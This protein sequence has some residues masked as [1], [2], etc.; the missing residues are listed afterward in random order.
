MKLNDVRDSAIGIIKAAFPTH[1]IYDETVK[2]G[3]VQGSFVIRIFPVT[4]NQDGVHYRMK[5]YFI[6]ISYKGTET[7]TNMNSVY[8]TLESAFEKA[9][10]VVSTDTIGTAQT[11]YLLPRN[12]RREDPTDDRFVFLFDLDI[13]DVVQE[14]EDHSEAEEMDLVINKV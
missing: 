8:D 13:N 12:L 11:R 1:K 5:S 10:E 6:S 2:A 3:F 14:V 9:F 4:N 7:F